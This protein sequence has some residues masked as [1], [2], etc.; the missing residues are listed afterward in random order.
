MITLTNL[1]ER[2]NSFRNKQFNYART[3]CGYCSRLTSSYWPSAYNFI[4][5]LFLHVRHSRRNSAMEYLAVKSVTRRSLPRRVLNVGTFV[6]APLETYGPR[7]EV[8][9]WT[10]STCNF[11]NFARAR[12]CSVIELSPRDLSEEILSQGGPADTPRLGYH[13]SP[14]LARYYAPMTWI[15]SLPSP[16]YPRHFFPMFKIDELARERKDRF[17]TRSL[18]PR[19]RSVENSPRIPRKSVP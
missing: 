4:T 6:S 14:R 2:L 7:E 13:S 9:Y 18:R 8:K 15:L 5:T 16:A 12:V 17:D 10:R 11:G 1:T 3:R 19:R